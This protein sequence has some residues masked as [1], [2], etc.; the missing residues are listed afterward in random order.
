M[1]KAFQ[2]VKLQ[3][4]SLCNLSNCYLNGFVI[5]MVGSH[6]YNLTLDLSNAHN[7]CYKSLC[8]RMRSHYIITI[9]QN[10]SSSLWNISIWTMFNPQTWTK[11]LT[12]RFKTINSQ[13][14]KIHSKLWTPKEWKSVWERWGFLICNF[15][16]LWSV[17]GL[18][19]RMPWPLLL[20][21]K[22][23]KQMLKDKSVGTF[24]FPLC[25]FKNL[26]FQIFLAPLCC[27]KDVGLQ[28]F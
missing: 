19:S 27:F 2:Y 17:L 28:F 26:R 20:K 10:I 24:T 14:M 23:R 7:Y 21:W 5:W 9:F 4:W 18:E 3:N 11:I 8:L 22:C 16:H 1:E 25:C 13:R 15:S 12:Q 6:F